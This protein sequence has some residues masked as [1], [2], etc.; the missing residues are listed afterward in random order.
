MGRVRSV[1][2]ELSLV[3]ARLRVTR[4]QCRWSRWWRRGL[5]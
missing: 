2:I 3:D 4:W 5:V 1:A